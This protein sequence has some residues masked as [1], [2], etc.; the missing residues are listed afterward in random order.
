M[1]FRTLGLLAAALSGCTSDAA[2]QDSSDAGSDGT[3][4]VNQDD[5]GGAAL[6]DSEAVLR[7]DVVIDADEWAAMQADMVDLLGEAGSGGGLGGAGGP[8]GGGGGPAG[9]DMS[10]LVDA[11]DGLSAGDACVAPVGAGEVDGTCTDAPVGLVCAPA[12][13]PGGPA[14]GGGPGGAGGAGGV[15]LT[16]RDP[17]YFEAMVT[18]AGETFEHVGLRYK[19]NSSLTSSWSA[20][21]RKMPFRLDLDQFADEHPEVDGLDI[22]GHEELSFG[23]NFGDDAQIRDAF[24]TERMREFGVPA[25]RWQFARVYVDVGEGPTYWGLYTMLEDPSGDP[26]L[27]EHY[28]T[29]EIVVYKPEGTCASFACFDEASFEKKTFEDEADW[30]DVIAAVEALNA[31][32]DAETWRADLEATFDVDGF[33]AWLAMNT[34]I[35]NWDAYGQ[36]AHNYYLYGDPEDGGRLTWVTWDHNLSMGASFGA[37]RAADTGD[38]ASTMFHDTVTEAWPLIRFLLDDPV[39]FDRYT[40]LLQATV[41]GPL[42]AEATDARLAALHALV[43]PWVVGADG[44][45]T[46]ST[47]ISSEAAFSA[48]VDDLVSHLNDRRLMVAEALGE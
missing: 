38:A 8:G 43:A 25:A 1:T 21:N 40:A 13:G 18:L 23:S 14:A 4:T 17:N 45:Q 5:D 47:T 27:E 37:G 32:T 16:S 9:G 2:L 48:S 46:G 35:D 28:G 42:A 44:E 29:D 12:G 19:G 26:M 41:D 6:F 30:S 22:D 7:V 33:L 34:A 11:C 20:G 39:Y 24:V 31:E 15:S 10:A 3:S 36:M